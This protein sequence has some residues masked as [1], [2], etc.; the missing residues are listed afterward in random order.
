MTQIH[1]TLIIGAGI[2][3]ARWAT[4]WPGSSGC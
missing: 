3:G 4:A 1:D 2:A